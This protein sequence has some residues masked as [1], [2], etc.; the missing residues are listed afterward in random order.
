MTAFSAPIAKGCRAAADGSASGLRLPGRSAPT[1]TAPTLTAEPRTNVDFSK[2]SVMRPE[3][4]VGKALLGASHSLDPEMRLSMESRLHREF[5]SVRVHSDAQASAAARS[6]RAAAFTSGSD[7]VFAAGAYQPH[8]RRGRL[9]IAHELVHVLQR[10]GSVPPA[11]AP[12]TGLRNDESEQQADQLVHGLMTGQPVRTP[13]YARPVSHLSLLPESWFRGQAELAKPSQDSAPGVPGVRHDLGEGVY[14]ADSFG[15]AEEYAEIRALDS[16]SA[17]EVLS[18][19]LDPEQLGRVLDL[20]KDPRFME[21]FESARRSM[22][23]VGERYRNIVDHVLARTGRRLEDFDVIIGPEGL[24]GGRQLC[25]RDKVVAARLRAAMTSTKL[26]PAGQQGTLSGAAGKA[27]GEAVPRNLTSTPNAAQ[28]SAT[29]PSPVGS[30]PG[31]ADIVIEA[32]VVGREVVAT[33]TS[34]GKSVGR[35]DASYSTKMRRLHIGEIRV[36]DGFKGRRDLHIGTRLYEHAIEAVTKLSG[37][38]DIIEQLMAAD[39]AA[40]A[41]STEGIVSAP[42]YKTCERLGFTIQEYDKD[43]RVLVS[44]RPSVATGGP[45]GNQPATT[46]PSRV[47]PPQAQST[48]RPKAGIG[49][50]EDGPVPRPRVGERGSVFGSGSKRP[51]SRKLEDTKPIVLPPL[52]SPGQP[53]SPSVASRARSTEPAPNS[54]VT[55]RGEAA[56]VPLRPPPSAQPKILPPE[57][58]SSKMGGRMAAANA[59]VVI[60]E[61]VLALVNAEAAKAQSQKAKAEYESQVAEIRRMM[62]EHPELGAT[63]WVG[64]ATTKTHADSA[65]HPG[66]QFHEVRVEYGS[67]PSYTPP[68]AVVDAGHDGPVYERQWIPPAQPRPEPGLD[69][70]AVR[71]M[72]AS[73][74]GWIDRLQGRVD[75]LGGEGRLLRAWHDRTFV[76]DTH[77][78]DEPRS[79]VR[80]AEIAVEQGRLGDADVSIQAA[81]ELL[82]GASV[83][84]DQYEGKPSRFR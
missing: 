80:S 51:F 68:S 81:R 21:H 39:N 63:V 11:S 10:R 48:A 6:V 2:V 20:T 59:S 78:L 37:R 69:T 40:A 31:A 62:T 77:I 22:A 75:L 73:V 8:T 27:S 65:N 18:G 26:V 46:T 57:E 43:N 42:A 29:S 61:K 16:N 79:H 72:L 74:S 41:A 71:K 47:A 14:F 84:I 45:A 55:L 17:G 13:L 60:L 35:L 4:V 52:H 7:I 82:R 12:L 32:I 38:V 53:V 1:S 3:S 36:A 58:L 50:D 19:T 25:V 76:L 34:H 83:T 24:R 5:A 33:A 64:W 56:P 66:P 67:K 15:V 23:V 30:E 44:R 28:A 70:G 49:A 9:L 54:A